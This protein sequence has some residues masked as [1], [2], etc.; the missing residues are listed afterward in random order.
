MANRDNSD[1]VRLGVYDHVVQQIKADL[2]PRSFQF[3]DPVTIHLLNQ[4][5][6]DAM[7]TDTHASHRGKYVI[8]RR[9]S[10]STY[11]AEAMAPADLV[12]LIT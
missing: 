1:P 8:Y 6:F 2:S 3:G 5:P 11:S 12:T 9:L 7:V 10:G 4:E